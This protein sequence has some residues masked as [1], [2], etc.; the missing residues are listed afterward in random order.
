MSLLSNVGVSSR[1]VCPHGR[2]VCPFSRPT[3]GVVVQL[4][5]SIEKQLEDLQPSVK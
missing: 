4:Q 5:K 3:C 2:V 1:R